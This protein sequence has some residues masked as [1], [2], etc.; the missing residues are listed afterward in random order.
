[1]AGFAFTLPLS[2]LGLIGLLLWFIQ[3][4]SN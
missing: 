3:L 2:A 4:G 1:M